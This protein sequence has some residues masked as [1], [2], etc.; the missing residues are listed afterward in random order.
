MMIDTHTHLYLEDFDGDFNETV[1]RAE[2]AGVD[3]FVFPA[4]EKSTFEKMMSTHLRYPQ[5]IFLAAGLHPVSVREETY[6]QELDFVENTIK[7][8]PYV[9]VGEIGIDCY[10]TTENISLQIQ[11]FERQIEIA[12]THNLPVIIH[13]RNS[14]NEIFAILDKRSDLN[15]RGIFH[16][17]SGNADDYEKIKSY[18]NFLFGLGGIITFK[19]SGM[20][21]IVEKMQMNE[22]VL[23]TDSPYLTPAPFRGKRNESANLVLIAKKIAEIKNMNIETVAEQTTLNAKKLFFDS[24]NGKLNT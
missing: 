9:A 7:N 12:C 11:A 16:A 23:E 4:I 18:G 8:F 17:F 5:K 6:K 19:N 3:T 2:L 21:A 20:T 15:L 14:F 10:W 13:A 1:A 22:I 24:E